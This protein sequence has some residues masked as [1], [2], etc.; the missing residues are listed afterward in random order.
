MLSTQ[1]E[2]IMN[3]S[4]S[5]TSIASEKG[6]EVDPIVARTAIVKEV[7]IGTGIVIGKGIGIKTVQV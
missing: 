1:E 2:K 4:V 6:N 3:V 5:D 7:W